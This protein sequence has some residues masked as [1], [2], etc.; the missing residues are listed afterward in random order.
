MLA[1]PKMNYLGQDLGRL[2]D[3]SLS[4][5]SISIASVIVHNMHED[6]ITGTK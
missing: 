5:V 3:A 6:Y 1:L 4:T 2:M